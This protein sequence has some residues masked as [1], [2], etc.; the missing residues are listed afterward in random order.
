MPLLLFITLNRPL[1]SSL[2]A[3]E[4]TE[5]RLKTTVYHYTH[6]YGNCGKHIIMYFHISHTAI[7]IPFSC[8]GQ[9]AHKFKSE[10]YFKCRGVNVFNDAAKPVQAAAY[11]TSVS[12]IRP[13]LI[14]NP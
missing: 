12:L 4:S 9:H 2:Q 10:G 11:S 1:R 3:S 6:N 13:I 5:L 7:K 14:Y 8:Q